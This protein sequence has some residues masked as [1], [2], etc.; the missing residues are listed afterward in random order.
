MHAP[1]NAFTGTDTAIAVTASEDEC[2]QRA[3]ILS[4]HTLLRRPLFLDPA[5][6][7]AV[8]RAHLDG[9]IWG[10]SRCLA[11]VLLPDSWQALVLLGANDSTDRLIRRFKAISARATEPRFKINGWLWARGFGQRAFAEDLDL[12]EE[13]R[14]LVS[15]PV[16]AG[17]SA[18]LA[19]Y[20][21][22]NSAWLDAPR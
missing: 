19:C 12:R 1:A 3:F 15:A 13:A 17:F 18:S 21:Y 20:P 10:S 4:A 14:K 22:W 2:K 16:S 9:S 5:G 11:W 6:A 7:R 8:S